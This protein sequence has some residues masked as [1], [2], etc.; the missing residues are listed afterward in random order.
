M[1]KL[2]VMYAAAEDMHEISHYIVNTLSNHI[3][4]KNL[5]T[6]IEVTF[7]RIVCN[8]YMYELYPDKDLAEKGYRKVTVKNYMIF[9]IVTEEEKAVNI[10][11]VIYG[12]RDH[13][14]LI[15]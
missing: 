10:M 13:K 4:A 9:Y 5:I 15:Q 1:Y 7:Q 14:N 3:A 11:R 8:P 6:Q 2:R 12:R